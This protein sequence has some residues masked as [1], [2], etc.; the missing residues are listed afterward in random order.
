MENIVIVGAGA[1]GR[2]ILLMAEDVCRDNSALAI[3]GFLDRDAKA[4]AGF[5]TPVG[6]I[7]DDDYQIDPDDRLVLAMADPK[8]RLKLAARFAAK[9][10]KFLTLVHPAAMVTRTATLG[11]GVT[12]A[13][14][15]HVA[16]CAQ[17]G[18]YVF[19]NVYASVGHDARVGAGCFFGPYAT[20]NGFSEVGDGVLLG[21]HAVVTPSTKVGAGAK[22]GA[23]SVVYK[24]VPPNHL[25]IGNP[26][27]A[28]AIY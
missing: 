5:S 8:L 1:L 22:V 21:T 25:A 11:E 15:C 3:K 24:P 2:E 28:H 16:D 26:A 23:G 7:G 27:K 4:L 12:V 6:I 13:P 20:V 10:A 19:L 17:V 9:G 18:A 14:F